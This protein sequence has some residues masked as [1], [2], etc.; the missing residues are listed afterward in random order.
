MRHPRL[1]SIIVLACGMH[2]A[3]AAA[4]FPDKAVRIVVGHSAGDTIDLIA[5]VSGAALAEGFRQPVVVEDQPGNHGNV[6]AARIAKS[7][8][9]GYTLLLAA[10]SF[11]ANASLYPNLQHQPLRDFAPVAR[12]ADVHQLLV[13]SASGAKTLAAFIAA[14]R[15]NPGKIILGS[16]GN[17]SPSHLAE[18][19]MKIRAGPL[20]TLHVPYKS[21]GPALVELLGGHIEALI[22]TMP[23]AYPHVKSGRLRALAVAAPKRAVPLPQVP[24]FAEAGVPGV[25]AVVWS[26]LLAPVGTPYDHVVRLRL[27][28]TKA[29]ASVELKSKLAALG[30][31][32]E[33]GNPDQFAEYLRAEV[34]KWSQVIKAAGITAE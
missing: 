25:E 2:A 10:S 18:E 20:N 3:G 8:P 5:R 21:S 7:R 6:A 26:G 17:A 9:D 28:V 34:A 11:A 1:I 27:G 22:V 29:L 15:A 30:A 24:T 16:A 19:L 4:E 23:F 33:A 12:L 14:I 32:P 31:E 13:V